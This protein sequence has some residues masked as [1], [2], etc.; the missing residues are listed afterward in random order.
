MQREGALKSGLISFSNRLTEMSHS[1]FPS[2][3]HAYR[4]NEDGASEL[5]DQNKLVHTRWEAKKEG[6][7][8]LLKLQK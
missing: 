6:K 5:F 4:V 7:L 8:G 1:N 2:Y 3:N